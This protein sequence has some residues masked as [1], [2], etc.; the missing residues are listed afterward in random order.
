MALI[1]TF[2]DLNFAEILQTVNWGHKSGHLVVRRDGRQATVDFSEGEVARASYDGRT[3]PEV[4][5][6]L[7][8]WREGEF[9]FRV[10]SEPIQRTV[11]EGM[12]GLILEGMKRLDEWGQ[13]EHE[14]RG[15]NVILR[16]RA[17]AVGDKFDTLSTEQQVILRLVNAQRDAATIIRESGLAPA[18]ALLVI[19]ELIA[20]GMVEKWDPTTDRGQVQVGDVAHVDLAAAEPDDA[21]GICS[22]FAPYETPSRREPK[23]AEPE[24]AVKPAV[25]E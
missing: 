3:G 15:L 24:A 14:M 10:T 18:H 7:L 9:E 12:D 17:G 19:T 4:I 21:P 16:Q 5:Y 23:A 6:R 25:K 11:T 20:E 2:D 13:V 8:G 1:G 22:Y